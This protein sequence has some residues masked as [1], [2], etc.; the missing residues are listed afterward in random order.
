MRPNSGKGSKPVNALSLVHATLSE[1]QDERDHWRSIC[2]KL[3]V[4]NL[5][6][7]ACLVMAVTSLVF[8]RP[9]TYF[10]TSSTGQITPLV[11]LSQP[12]VTSA[13]VQRFAVNTITEALSLNFRQ[14]RSQLNH[15]ESNFTT[16]GFKSFLTQLEGTNWIKSIEAGYFTATAIELARPVLVSQGIGPDG[17]YGYVIE[18][19]ITLL[20]ENQ[21]ERRKQ[22]LKTR[23]IVV[24]VP[25]AEKADGIAVD[26]VFVG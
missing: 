7:A 11:P 19:P 1:L 15:V 22:E 6:T 24:R 9:A 23:I 2:M 20:L 17:R 4:S 12:T 8:F 21:T 16:D 25:T 14:Y 26:K 5:V 18:V 3:G 13:V 10:S